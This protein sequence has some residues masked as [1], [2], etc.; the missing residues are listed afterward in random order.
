MQE[1]ADVLRHVLYVFHGVN[2]RSTSD[3]RSRNTRHGLLKLP[4]VCVFGPHHVLCTC[5]KQWGLRTELKMQCR[6]IASHAHDDEP[7]V[8]HPART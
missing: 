2:V 3:I 5:A 7:H 8:T 6:K 1:R 4:I